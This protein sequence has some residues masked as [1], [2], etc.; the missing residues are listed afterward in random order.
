MV[1][2]FERRGNLFGRHRILFVRPRAE[3]EQLAA[4]GTEGAVR[5]IFPPARAMT[6]RTFHKKL[7]AASFQRLA[8]TKLKRA[9]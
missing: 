4:L 5:V 6:G 9:D 8:K 1:G 2:I 3:V 7:F